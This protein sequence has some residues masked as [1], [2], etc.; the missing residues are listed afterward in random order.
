MDDRPVMHGFEEA[1]RVNQSISTRC[2]DETDA[3]QGS[4]RSEIMLQCLLKILF[5]L[6]VLYNHPAFFC[7][8]K[9][10]S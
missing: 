9:F 4:A 1:A 7:P 8:T 3:C 10:V 2:I 6:H 5:I